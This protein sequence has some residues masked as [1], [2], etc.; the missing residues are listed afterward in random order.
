MSKSKPF[1][2]YNQQLKILRSRG[3]EIKNG[4]KAIRFLKRENYYN[5]ING[6][7]ILFLERDRS[8]GAVVSPEKY[9][10]GATFE[11]IANLYTFDRELRNLFLSFMLRFEANLKTIIAYRFTE[12]YPRQAHPYLEISNYS[13]NPK[14]AR[15]VLNTISNL[16]KQ[17][18]SQGKENNNSVNH[19]VNKHNH[20]PLWVLV[21]Y[22][23]F[24]NVSYM[25]KSMN[26]TLRNTISKDFADEYKQEYNKKILIDTDMLENIIKT[27]NS[28]RNVA[29]HEEIFYTHT[30]KKSAAMSKIYNIFGLKTSD[31]TKTDLY[32]LLL[33]L[34][35]VLSKRDYKILTRS[36]RDLFDDY[37]NEFSCIS[38][39][40]ILKMM[41]FGASWKSEI[42]IK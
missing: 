2:T 29:A 7:K 22:L 19:Y 21:K 38:F 41:G 12:S 34:R 5:V 33:M 36:L 20:V 9:I 26:E 25:Y 27:M 14:I 42:M 3:L 4:S 6:Y 1:K 11:D 23:T 37:N 15:D 17:I 16:Y 10:K 28:F 13:D 35:V 32:T 40:E 30:L 8:N 31:T 18:S 39:D 24:G